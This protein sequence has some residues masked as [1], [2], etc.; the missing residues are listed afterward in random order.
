[1][2]LTLVHGPRANEAV[3]LTYHAR[4]S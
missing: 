4:G 3:A 2:F 1:V